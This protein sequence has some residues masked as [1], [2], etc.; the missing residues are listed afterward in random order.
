[1]LLLL[2]TLNMLMPVRPSL[3][4]SY[5]IFILIVKHLSN[6]YKETG[7]Q[8]EKDG[9]QNV[10]NVLDRTYRA[11]VFHP[12]IKGEKTNNQCKL[13]ECFTSS[14]FLF[15]FL[16]TE[17]CFHHGI[18][19]LLLFGIQFIFIVC[20]SFVFLFSC[21]SEK[22]SRLVRQKLRIAR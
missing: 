2:H 11:S 21:N 10:Q 15:C 18:Q 7:R 19:I 4:L 12:K 13:S 16:S 9:T 5:T 14:V 8:L 3:H 6:Y 17:A 22:K 1:M 20:L